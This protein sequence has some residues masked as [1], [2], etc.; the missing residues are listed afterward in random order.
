MPSNDVWVKGRVS[1]VTDKAVFVQV[2]EVDGEPFE[3]PSSADTCFPKSQMVDCAV[4]PD[5]IEWGDVVGFGVPEWLA[6][7]KELV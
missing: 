7:E 3:Q 2:R 1:T 5:D 6:I 4:D